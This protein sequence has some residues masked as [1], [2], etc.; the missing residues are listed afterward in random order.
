MAVRL[1]RKMVVYRVT[2]YAFSFLAS[3]VKAVIANVALYVAFTLLT[4][5]VSVL[6]A[7][8]LTASIYY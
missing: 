4:A 7:P 6:E 8:G 2:D 5:C 1:E 3:L